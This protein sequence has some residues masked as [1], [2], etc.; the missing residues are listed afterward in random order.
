[1]LLFILTYANSEFGQVA[2]ITDKIDFPSKAECLGARK[3]ILDAAVGQGYKRAV[4]VCFP[5]S[6]GGVLDRTAEDLPVAPTMPQR[7]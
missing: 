5:R 7:K 4:A 2:A 6:F 3:E 1:M